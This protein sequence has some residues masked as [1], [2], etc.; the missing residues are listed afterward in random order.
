MF[1]CCRVLNDFI[2]ILGYGL[3]HVHVCCQGITYNFT[4]MMTPSNGNIFR[5]T[6]PLCGKPP[7]PGEFPS[8]RTMTRNFDV[9]FDLRKNKRL[10]K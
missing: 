2:H 4:A 3:W 9:F 6:G 10:I 5:I 8:Q 1:Y 7:V